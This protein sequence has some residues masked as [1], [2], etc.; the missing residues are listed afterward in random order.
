[1]GV[2]VIERFDKDAYNQ[3]EQLFGIPLQQIR[4]I[5]A[6]RLDIAEYGKLSYLFDVDASS[7]AYVIAKSLSGQIPR[8]RGWLI[9]SNSTAGRVTV[10]LYPS[11]TL[12][13]F[14][15]FS[16]SKLAFN[17]QVFIEGQKDDQLR[18]YWD[19]MDIGTKLFVQADAKNMYESVSAIPIQVTAVPLYN[20]VVVY[21][22]AGS[23]LLT[24]DPLF[25]YTPEVS[26]ASTD[27]AEVAYFDFDEV[28]ADIKSIFVNLVWAMKVTGTGSGKVKWQIAS[29]THA[30]PGT[31]VDITDEV[32][33]SFTDYVEV[34]RSGTIHKISGVPTTTPFTIR[35][36]SANINATSVEAKVKSNT[37][38]RVAYKV[39]T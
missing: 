6:R 10:K 7:K 39:K 8:I 21:P 15:D 13:A 38:I 4:D 3:L 12:V 18:L 34:G 26:N 25:T 27:W 16:A 19:G 31:Y 14:V 2:I 28:S 36:I 1:M 37:Y 32:S 30:N 17:K 23:D 29:G 9:L 22:F 11:G 5:E 33:T 24:A 20:D 35:C